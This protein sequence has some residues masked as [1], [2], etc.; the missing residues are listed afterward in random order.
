MSFLA[1]WGLTACLVLC[2]IGVI[3]WHD[4]K[5]KQGRDRRVT[6]DEV[7]ISAFVALCPLINIVAALLLLYYFIDQIAPQVVVFGDKE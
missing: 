2:L 7:L 3:V 4:F 6:L 5:H 1:A